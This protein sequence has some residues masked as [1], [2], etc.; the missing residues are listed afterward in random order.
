V[1]TWKFETG[2]RKFALKYVFLKAGLSWL[3]IG[4]V[5]CFSVSGTEAQDLVH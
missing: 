3:R 1:I 4:A 5:M 2:D